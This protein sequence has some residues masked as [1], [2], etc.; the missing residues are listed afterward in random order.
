MRNT[1]YIL[2]ILGGTSSLA[3]L[4]PNL[5]LAAETATNE[6]AASQAGPPLLAQAGAP[7][8][9]AARARRLNPTGRPIVLTVPARD[10]AALLGDLP[11]TISAD[12]SLRFPA[13][14]VLQLLEP[15]LAPNVLAALRTALAG[16]A[17]IGPEDL[18]AAGLRTEY[19]PRVLEVR[20][21]IPVESRVSRSLSVAPRDR[22]VVGE[23]ARPASVSAYLNIRGSV[24]LVEEGSDQ[25]F[26][27]PVLFLNGAARIGGIVAESDAIWSPDR[28]GVQFQRLGSRLVLDRPDD[29]LRI[30]AGD[31]LTQGQGFQ[32][33]PDIAGIGIMRAYSVLNPLQI[34]RPRGDRTFR[35]DRPS[36]VEVLVNGQQVRRLQLA[37]G[38]YNLRDFP[39]AQG[40]NDIRLNVLDDTGRTEVLRFNVFMDQSQ[41]ASG[42][43]EFGLYAGVNAPLGLRGPRYSDKAIFSGFYRRGVSD[44]V[45]LGANV[46]A[47]KDIQMGGLELVAGTAIGTIGGHVSYSR[48][49]GLGDGFAA[50]ANFQRQFR[51]ANGMSD[52]FN[53][54]AEHRSRR[55]APVTF[56]LADNPY[57]YELGGGYSHAFNPSL[58]GGVD[59]RFSKGRGDNRDVHNYRATLGWRLSPLASLTAET[60]YQQDSR[61]GEVSGFLTLSVRLGRYSTLRS[62][63][64]TRDNRVRASFQTLR[65][66]GVGSFNV[67]SDIE[68]SD[69]GADLA[70]NANYVGNRAELGLT[71]FGTFSR[72]FS[73]SQNQRTTLRLASS[74]ALADGAF[75]IGRP[76]YD[77]F[78]IV[79][80][81]KS[82]KRTA[83]TVEPSPFGYTASTGALG[84]AT[85]P[86]LSSYADRTLAVDAPEAPAGT[87]I[88]QGSFKLFPAYRSGYVLEVGSDYNVTAL[89]T[90]VDVDGQS[91]ALIS[92][93]ATELAHPERP[94]TTV[95]T[96][97]Q[98]RFGLTGL[99]AGRWRLE[100]LDARKSIFEIE[101]PQDAEGIVR[102]GEISP[103]RK[104]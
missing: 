24:D 81:H 27:N 66:T 40:S 89:G 95:F 78:A 14:R 52:T 76:I 35:L 103:L 36:T 42:I 25:G 80:P 30:T 1:G 68:R 79:R 84:A 72:D 101:I 45:T 17:E 15:V 31:L 86:S 47:D 56:F 54:Y 2:G 70:V 57:R 59:A 65:G 74:L 12:D 69:F 96:N 91:I 102:L 92:G 62:E 21:D 94:A 33:A 9:P 85:M 8:V 61:G 63:Y 11:L 104:P 37:P 77:A 28:R 67:T 19:D 5:A 93:K 64:D 83:V 4:L 46:Q 44:F 99:A 6:T 39:F 55:F 22:A 23:L 29:V 20:F 87:D 58:Y 34:I 49:R 16:R 13:E 100:M 98:G 3:L 88:G 71:H 48:T 10:G 90:M 82:L 53:L 50:Q 38:N 18:Q 41:L 26:G 32:T 7:A 60:R 75:S 73:E 51:R 97:R 43:D